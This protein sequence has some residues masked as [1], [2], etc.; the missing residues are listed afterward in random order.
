MTAHVVYSA[1]DA[2]RPATMSRRVICD[3]IREAIGFDGLL[4]SD[5]VSMKALSGDFGSR[6]KAILSAGCDMVLHCNGVMA[7]MQAVAEAVPVLGGDAA[8]RADAAMASF[9]PPDSANE[10]ELR[11]EFDQLVD[12]S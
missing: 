7:E 12:A 9:A 1:I 6:A 8:R 4:M 2:D 3:V 5:D 10:L 11:S